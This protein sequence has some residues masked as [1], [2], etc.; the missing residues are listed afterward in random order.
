[1]I[2]SRLQRFIEAIKVEWGKTQLALLCCVVAE[3]YPLEIIA[4][5]PAANISFCLNWESNCSRGGKIEIPSSSLSLSSLYYILLSAR[6]LFGTALDEI[7]FLSTVPH[8]LCD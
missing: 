4:A 8:K 2:R 7:F 5:H 6:L 3:P 1:M